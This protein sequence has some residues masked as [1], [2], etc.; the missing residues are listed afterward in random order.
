MK[1]LLKI[2]KKNLTALGRY[3][4]LLFRKDSALVHIFEI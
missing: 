4:L 2:I 1:I 3:A